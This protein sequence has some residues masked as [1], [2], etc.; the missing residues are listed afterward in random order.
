MC[1]LYFFSYF[2]GRSLIGWIVIS[3]ECCVNFGDFINYVFCKVV[4]G[5]VCYECGILVEMLL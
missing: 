5:I 3:G 2:F 1:S 4:V